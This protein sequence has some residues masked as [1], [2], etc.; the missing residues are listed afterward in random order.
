[1]PF[2]TIFRLTASLLIFLFQTSYAGSSNPS[3]SHPNVLV[4]LV[5]DLGYA[6]LSINNPDLNSPTSH[7]NELAAAGA[8]F[9]RHYTESSCSPSRAALITGRYPARA[10][11]KPNGFGLPIELTNLPK[12][13]KA[14]GYR[15]HQIGKW[16]LG[17]LVKESWPDQQGFDTWLGFLN[18][19]LMTDA[20]RSDGFHYGD[21]THQDAY[22]QNEAGL[23]KRYPGHMTDV[24]TDE[25]IRIIREERN[26]PWF[27]Y[28]AYLAPHEPIQARADYAARFPNTPAGR[29]AAMIAH[30]DDRVGDL[31]RA[32]GET[33]QREK[34]IVVF[35]SDNGGTNDHLDNNAPFAGKKV[36]YREG[37]LRTPLLISWPGKIVGQQVTN[38]VVSIMDIFP[39]VANLAEVPVPNNLDGRP[40]F[41]RNGALITGAAPRPLFWDISIGNIKRYGVLSADGRWRYF[42]DYAGS[43]SLFD[44]SSDPIGAID[45]IAT[46]KNIAEQ[47][48]R[49][50][51]QWEAE[52][53][54]LNLQ[55]Q[56]IGTDGRG[57]MRGDKLLRTATFGDFTVGIG[58][59]PSQLSNDEAVILAQPP[60]LRVTATASGVHVQFHEFLT[61]LPPLT[62]NKCNSIIFTGTFNRKIEK[63]DFGSS[64]LAIYVNGKK[65]QFLEK[66]IPF[67]DTADIS[68][69]TFVGQDGDGTHR[70]IGKLTRPIFLSR[71][72]DAQAPP[73]L[74]VNT[75]E[76]TLCPK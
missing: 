45:V 21:T 44:L 55:W 24:V 22:L 33:G 15:T 18:Q 8:R 54:Q 1:M 57:V 71:R 58:V 28:A 40:L 43:G 5:D 50:F 48:L 67:L 61:D 69:P 49:S 70:L 25:T 37:G 73:Q 53:A 17:H 35:A 46:H 30:L 38:E 74:S 65:A 72:A 63:T 14:A 13:F 27:I 20:D 4:I 76:N 56:K 10:N 11:F 36:E 66:N 12:A 60:A 47:L 9:T 52:T 75:L 68:A 6:D 62:I 2:K 31:L 59:T 19:W 16:H 3:Q 39:T 51:Y 29:Y 42:Q 26:T 7:L 64:Q 23:I 32:L 41:K 34:T